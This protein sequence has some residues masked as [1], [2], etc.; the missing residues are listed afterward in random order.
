MTTSSRKIL[1]SLKPETVAMLD[2]AAKILGMCRSDVIRR[3][4]IRDLDYVMSHEVPNMQ[5]FHEETKV[6]HGGWLRSRRWFGA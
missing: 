4:L 6:A 1:L 5:R 3:S 2:Q